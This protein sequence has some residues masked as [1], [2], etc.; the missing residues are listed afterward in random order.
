MGSLTLDNVWV[1]VQLIYS[2]HGQNQLYKN[3]NR[4]LLSA[5]I[6]MHP[7]NATTVTQSMFPFNAFAS[8]IHI[9]RLCQAWE[10]HLENF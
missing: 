10:S 7:P 3:P 4:D 6:I 5:L 2:Q 9:Y 1:F 8:Y